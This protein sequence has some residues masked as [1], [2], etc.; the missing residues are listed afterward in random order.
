MALEEINAD[1]AARPQWVMDV[2]IARI[3]AMKDER[4]KNLYFFNKLTKKCFDLILLIYNDKTD[5]KRGNIQ[6]R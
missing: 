4:W 6:T 1:G 5:W 3:R 2:P